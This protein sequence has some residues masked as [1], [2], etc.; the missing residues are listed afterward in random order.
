MIESMTGDMEDAKPIE[1]GSVFPLTTSDD[2]MSVG[3]TLRDYFAAKAL[4]GILVSH[5]LK[6]DAPSISNFAK[7]SY[8]YA[9]AML[10]ARGNK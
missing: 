6:L 9:D 8:T 4:Q 1:F 10:L 5:I 7:T 2:Y 3:M